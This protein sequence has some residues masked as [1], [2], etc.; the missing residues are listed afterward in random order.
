MSIAKNY[1]YNVIYQVITLI[2]PLVT[3][4]YISRV[5]GSRGIG[6]NAYT[7][8]IIQYFILFGTI[9]ISLYGNRAIAYVRDDKENLS[10]TFWGIFTLQI[11]TTLIAYI[12]FLFFL[13]ITGKYQNIFLLQSLFLLAAMVDVSWL[14]MG[15]EDFKKTV[16][17]NLFVKLVGVV[18]IFIFVKS[19]E[20]LWKY[21]LI[22]SLSQFMGQLTLWFYIPKIIKRVKI[23]LADVKKHLGPSLTL[24]LPQIAIQI[25]LV[26]NKTMLGYLSNTNEVGFFDNSDKIVKMALSIVTATGVVM[27][28]RV[29][30]TFAKGD[31]S[32]VNDYLYLSFGFASYLSFPLMFGLMGIAEQFTPWFFGPEF[33]KTN[34]IIFIISPIIVFIAWSNV[35]GQQYLMPTGKMRGY[36]ISVIVGAIINF[37]LNLL[38]IPHFQSLGTSLATLI[39]EFTVTFVQLLFLSG[40]VKYKTLFASTWKYFFS[41]LIM[42]SVIKVI[43]LNLNFGFITTFIQI[44][45]GLLIYP[46]L[47]FIFKNELNRKLFIK[48][49]SF[50]KRLVK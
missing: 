34:E 42:Y 37:I 7:N 5:L 31:L 30:N 3:V 48:G 44:I 14:F 49:L 1:I 12:V 16:T 32:K 22:L 4:P 45:I 20:D 40:Q 11:S 25:Y 29:A 46:L 28:P 36:T 35:I 39:A 33:S 27:L 9:G 24:F 47:L 8:S 38:L 26:L 15:L 23:K 17:R 13:K 19:A 18:C 21:V 41:G 10:R 43:G 2:V 50:I 6:I